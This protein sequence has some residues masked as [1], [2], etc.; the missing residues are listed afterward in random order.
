M[1]FVLITVLC[2]LSI[3]I[4]QSWAQSLKRM[5]K[6]VNYIH[7]SECFTFDYCHDGIFHFNHIDGNVRAIVWQDGLCS[8]HLVKGECILSTSM[9]QLS[10]K[11]ANKL[12][13]YHIIN[14]GKRIKY[15]SS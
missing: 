9:E 7:H 6:W 3:A 15:C 5:I 8:I 2:V 12:L 4:L 13:T 1:K 14:H 10:R 11:M